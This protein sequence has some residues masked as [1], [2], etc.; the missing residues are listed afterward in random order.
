MKT[1]GILNTK[2]TA[3]FYSDYLNFNSP[4]GDKE[5]FRYYFSIMY[6]VELVE[7][8]LFDNIRTSHKFKLRIEMHWTI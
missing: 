8:E 1:V 3:N 6:D 7:P 4:L 2:E 5:R